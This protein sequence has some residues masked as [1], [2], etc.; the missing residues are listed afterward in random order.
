MD[1]LWFTR[2]T[3]HRRSRDTPELDT[4]MSSFA[5]VPAARPASAAAP[6]ARASSRRGSATRG[7]ARATT[8]AAST[9]DA[10]AL[11]I[12]FPSCAPGEGA[13]GRGLFVTGEDP[14]VPLVRT[15]L[16][17]TVCVPEAVGPAASDACVDAVRALYAG[18][19]EALGVAP[20]EPVVEFLTRG[21][22]PKDL[23]V[24]VALAWATRAVPAW[25]AYR[26]E[27][28][29]AAFDALYLASEDELEALQDETVARMAVGS[30][31]NYAAGWGQLRSEYPEVVRVLESIEND[32][33]DDALSME[34]DFTWARACAHTRAMSGTLGGGACAFV[35]PGVDLANHS[36]EPNAV[37]SVSADAKAFELTWDTEH[38]TNFGKR[39]APAPPK[40]G[41]EVLIC[42]GARMPNALLMLH[43]GF[44]DPTNP[45]DQLPMECLLPGARIIRSSV[46]AR[47]GKRLSDEKD[48]RA[49]WAA[50]QMMTM[51]NPTTSEGDA[52][53]DLRCVAA[54]R[55]AANAALDAFPTA[56]ADDEAALAD[57]APAMTTR[58]EMCVRYRLMQ[59]RNIQAFVRFLDT[60][61]EEVDA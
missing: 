21:E 2:A 16:S 9:S 13:R 35:V 20:P 23:R 55:D 10:D 29:P 26:R 31:A 40:R 25:R 22:A 54:M 59:K 42:Y 53:S 18:W 7:D 15:P 43:Y 50:R 33:D 56:A 45:N 11:G 57:G 19:E 30:G 58:M 51:S 27:T 3:H 39:S 14:A 4:V 5:R 52:Q 24:A 61:E 28:V 17:V 48:A 37:F 44:L 36:F 38:S 34:E 8:A 41:D 47:A 12:A 46:V 60:L 32:D 1:S 6:H 49:E